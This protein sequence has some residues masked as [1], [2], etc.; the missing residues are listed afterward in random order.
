[1]TVHIQPLRAHEVVRRILVEHGWRVDRASGPAYS[2]RHPAV[3]DEKAARDRL[4]GV[5]LLTSP[6]VRIAFD[7]HASSVPLG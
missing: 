7:P 5:G 4:S 1:M 3:K 6:A 2:A